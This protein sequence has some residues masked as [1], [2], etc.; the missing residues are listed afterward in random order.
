MPLSNLPVVACIPVKS[1]T[2]ISQSNLPL[3]DQ[4]R[5]IPPM[6]LLFLL[7]LLLLSQGYVPYLCSRSDPARSPSRNVTAGTTSR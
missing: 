3:N 7:L 2:Q 6:L 1:P 4:A 5:S